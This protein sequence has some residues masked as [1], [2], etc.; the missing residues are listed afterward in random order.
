MEMV[1]V[2]HP[3]WAPRK[4][5]T[6]E[7]VIGGLD[8]A[9]K[10]LGLGLSGA[11][12]YQKSRSNDITEAYKNAQEASMF[13]PAKQVAGID[14]IDGIAGAVTN[15][16]APPDLKNY[17]S[18]AIV[19]P[20]SPVFK[21]Q[22]VVRVDKPKASDTTYEILNKVQASNNPMVTV[23]GHPEPLLKN[24]VKSITGRDFD[25]K[26]DAVLS[27]DE[28]YL[29]MKTAGQINNT[30]QRVGVADRFGQTQET[31]LDNRFSTF[32]E[33]L[34]DPASR[35]AIG[36]NAAQKDRALAIELLMGEDQAPKGETREQKIARYNDV[37]NYR[38]REMASSF[39]ILLNQGNAATETGI[40]E[41]LPETFRAKVSG[42]IQSLTNQPEGTKMGPILADIAD[43]VEREKH[44][45]DFSLRERIKGMG[46][47]FSDLEKADPARFKSII[48]SATNIDLDHFRD[49]EALKK[50][51]KAMQAAPQSGSEL[52][53]ITNGQETHTI[54]KSSLEEAMKDGFKVVR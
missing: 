44:L 12:I 6:F 45:A 19:I 8:T 43:S 11:E 47:G 18:G 30:L 37:P 4:P 53:T 41:Q 54:P 10:I 3:G 38:A 21:G 9:A 27:T 15:P 24:N 50:G 13:R 22:P 2:S 33:K 5:S 25:P 23:A 31:K 7:K 34:N 26:Q 35:V 17:E 51:I 42:W 32:A 36:R 49:V 52:V 46:A 16:D 48:N 28:A 39:A 40:H 1:Q 29:A 20:N 14:P